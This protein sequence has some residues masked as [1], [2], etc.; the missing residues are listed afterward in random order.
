[1]QKLIYAYFY[2]E[3]KK[4]FPV[5]SDRN[6]FLFAKEIILLHFKGSQRPFVPGIYIQHFVYFMPSIPYI[7]RHTLNLVIVVS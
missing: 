5:V 6:G 4:F 3:K 1:M 2:F 7:R